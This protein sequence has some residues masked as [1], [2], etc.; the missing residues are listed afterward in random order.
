MTAIRNFGKVLSLCFLFMLSVSTGY[1]QGGEA[2]SVDGVVKDPSGAVVAN[3][4]VEITNPV[5]GRCV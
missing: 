4:T 5:S 1:A 3:A 2:G